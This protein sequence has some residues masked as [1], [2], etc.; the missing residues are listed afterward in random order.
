MIAPSSRYPTD[1]TIKPTTSLP[2]RNTVCALFAEEFLVGSAVVCAPGSESLA[3]TIKLV[4]EVDV[5]FA[6]EQAAQVHAGPLQV[7]GIDL[8]VAPVERSIGIVVI[9]FAFSL[10]ILGALDG[11]GQPAIGAELRAGVLLIGGEG[12]AMLIDTR[13][14]RIRGLHATG[15]DQWGPPMNHNGR[16]QAEGVAGVDFD[17]GVSE[18]DPYEQCR[19]AE[20]NAQGLE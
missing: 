15:D 3:F 9:N 18:R 12:T 11:K 8:K 14:A 7:N 17:N 4:S 10:G 19:E 16:F 5:R 1:A 6:I 2:E 20:R 13:G